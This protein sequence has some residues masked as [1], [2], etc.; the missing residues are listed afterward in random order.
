MYIVGVRGEKKS[1]YLRARA[2]PG[3]V[4][5]VTDAASTYR[6]AGDQ[7][8]AVRRFIEIGVM[9]V[10]VFDSAD[11]Y[12]LETRVIPKVKALLDRESEPRSEGN[13]VTAEQAA[14]HG[15]T[16]VNQAPAQKRE[17]GGK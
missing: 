12:Y 14:L 7:S 10:K 3:L 2:E 4:K 8:D 5:E 11:L 13:V 16:I 9:A 1:K 6:V 17:R 15:S